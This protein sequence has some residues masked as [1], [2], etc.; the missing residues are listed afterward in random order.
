[1]LW[2]G[3]LLAKVLDVG[4]ITPPIGL[5][6]F[7]IKRA[8]GDTIRLADIFRGVTWFFVADLVAIALVI[9]FPGLVTKIPSLLVM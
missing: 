1:M 7:V 6:V 2:F 3:I 9:S 8:V 4:L 5:N